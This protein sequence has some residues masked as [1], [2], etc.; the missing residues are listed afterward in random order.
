MDNLPRNKTQHYPPKTK[1]QREGKSQIGM[2]L[3]FATLNTQ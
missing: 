1:N 3:D 2:K